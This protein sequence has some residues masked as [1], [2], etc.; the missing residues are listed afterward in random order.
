VLR[1]GP[2]GTSAS[3]DVT[4]DDGSAKQK[5]DYEI[6]LAHIVFGA[7]ETDKTFQV[8]INDDGY[9]EGLE[10]AVLLLQRPVGGVLGIPSTAGLQITDNLPET[11]SNPIDLSSD[12]VGQHYHDFLYRQADQ[13]GQ[14]FWTNGI[15]SCGTD[16]TCRQAKRVDV[17]TAFFLSIEFQQTGYFVIRAYKAAFGNLASNP[18]YTVFLRD[19]LGVGNGVIVGQ[20]SWEAQLETNKQ[21]YLSDFVSRPEFVVQF[22]LGGA[23]ATYVDNLFLN[24]G[25]T[26]TITE[27]SAAI[28]A[29]GSGNTSGR[30]AALKS[31]I[32]S[33]SLFNAQYNQAFVLMQYYGYLRRNPDDAPD[34]NF[35]GYNFL[36]AKM[37]S[38]TLPGEDARNESVALARVRRAEMVKAFIISAEYRE[39]F[40]G[41]GG[42]NQQGTVEIR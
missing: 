39:R 17:S 15:E 19:Q 3:V 13:A 36:L 16:A 27:R 11:S 10:V 1:T 32:E 42:G 2:S 35:N 33:G 25:A 28:S 34:N 30:V 29:Y 24:A 9:T 23:A 20:G 22:P 26:P 21:N 40:F 4:S 18:R 37:N 8:L 41:A 14:D 7:G 12:F 5:G 31:V 38:F 6:V